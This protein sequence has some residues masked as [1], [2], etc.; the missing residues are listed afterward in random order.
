MIVWIWVF[1]Y[2]SIRIF[3]VFVDYAYPFIFVVIR[4]NGKLCL[5]CAG[6]CRGLVPCIDLL[7]ENIA[8]KIVLLYL[9]FY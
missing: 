8:N 6:E 2:C 3:R 5:V 1:Y 4:L 9:L 7:L